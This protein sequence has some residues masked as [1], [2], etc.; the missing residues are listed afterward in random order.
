MSKQIKQNKTHTQ[1]KT[2]SKTKMKN[3]NV[4]KDAKSRRHHNGNVATARKVQEPTVAEVESLITPTL[5]GGG[6]HS[7][8]PSAPPEG[9]YHQA[10]N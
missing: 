9:G 2:Q 8:P 5:Y 4:L 6:R 3:K 10:A 7:T 1:N